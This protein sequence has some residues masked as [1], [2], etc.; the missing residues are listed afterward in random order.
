MIVLE[1]V[2]EGW[3]KGRVGQK[4]GVFPSNF[5]EEITE[6]APEPPSSSSHNDKPTPA[7]HSESVDHTPAPSTLMRQFVIL[8]PIMRSF[9]RAHTRTHTHAHT[10]THTHTPP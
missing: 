9:V 8:I 3:W 4:E 2:E 7:P 5:V 10:H 1:V 6:E